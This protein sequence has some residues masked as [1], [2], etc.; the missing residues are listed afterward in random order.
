MKSI[1]TFLVS[2]LL[3]SKIGRDESEIWRVINKH[4]RHGY[5]CEWVEAIGD[6]DPRRVLV[7]RLCKRW[8]LKSGSLWGGELT[9]EPKALSE[10]FGGVSVGTRVPEPVLPGLEKLPQRIPGGEH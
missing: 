2:G 1:Y 10:R 3:E 4:T 6:Q 5:V 9:A 7:E 8:G